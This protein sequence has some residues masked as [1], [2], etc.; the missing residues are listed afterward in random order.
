[1]KLNINVIS[2]L[3]NTENSDEYR[4]AERLKEILENELEHKNV[5]GDITI[6]S[7]VKLYGQK[8]KDIDLFVFGYLDNYLTKLSIMHNK[9]MVHEPVIIKSFCVCIELKSHSA[10]D[11]RREGQ[12]L[13]VPYR[14]NKWS[15]ATQQSEDQK[16]S[17][18][19]F[20]KNSMKGN[21]ITPY[22][23]NLIWLSQVSELSLRNLFEG[24]QNALMGNHNILS[25]TFSLKKL[26]Q[27]C[28]I[29]KRP[30][31][32]NNNFTLKS[33]SFSN[34]VSIYELIKE[35]FTKNRVAYG[36]LTRKKIE[37][38]TN[39]IIGKQKYVS[40]IGNELLMI[41]GR[42]GTGKTVKLIR[43]ACDLA[44]NHGK[45]CLI[46]TYNKVL[47]S[48]IHR[49]LA[50]AKIPDMYNSYTVSIQT[51]HK[52]IYEIIIGL[53]L[54]K[55][56]RG[57]DYV[58]VFLDNYEEYLKEVNEYI[59][60]GLVE[61]TDIQSLFKKRHDQIAWD[62]ILIDEAQDSNDL[63]KE[64]LY[65]LFGSE[66]IIIADG[67]DQMVRSLRP[68]SWIRGLP[69]FHK[70]NEKR[71]LRQKFNLVTFVNRY[72]ERF[73][74]N[75]KLDPIGE[76]TGGKVIICKRSIPYDVL[77]KQFDLCKELGNDAYDMLFLAP[78]NLVSKNHGSRNFSLTKDFRN[79]G[80]K[81]WDGTSRKLRSE[82]PT[83]VNE[84][85][86]LQY[87]SC[88]GIEG[89]TT[90]CL[91]FDEFIKYKIESFD[92]IDSKIEQQ[93]LFESQDAKKRRHGHLWGLIALTRSI[94]TLIIT[95]EDNSA[96]FSQ[97]LL[98][99]ADEMSDY[100]QIIE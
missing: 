45:R 8:V 18:L 14:N 90:V 27:L 94:D 2:S 74:I 42:A 82:Y 16:Y 81:I 23:Y 67:V 26:F 71:S 78:P 79:Q 75:W 60:N 70:T 19:N 36:E 24:D 96:V 31:K 86:V 64:I 83:D 46:L 69:S 9:L 53:G 85:R 89:W 100:V 62:Y 43:I 51:I 21:F 49:L 13:K 20:L 6:A 40:A 38:I 56:Y 7:N 99:L 68:C 80:F 4:A 37:N 58:D 10:R 29:Q 54:G 33:I 63:E 28:A 76:I 12:I 15:D 39:N 84:F 22:I 98:R 61:D 65:R 48:D 88:R 1:M 72:A 97:E 93:G 57:N 87:D 41:S 52:F 95:L 25:S 50:L 47:V 17:M 35:L 92:N 73:D 44:T 59:D 32:I 5:G 91:C 34:T 11:I 77:I 30:I 3:S 55:S 66:N